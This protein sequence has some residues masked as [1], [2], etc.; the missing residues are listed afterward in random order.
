MRPTCG[1][2][3]W[4]CWNA[5][6]DVV[7]RTVCATRS[8]SSADASAKEMLKPTQSSLLH[9]GDKPRT[10][11]RNGCGK[12]IGRVSG[13]S[14]AARYRITFLPRRAFQRHQERGARRRGVGRRKGYEQR[15]SASSCRQKVEHNSTCYERDLTQAVRRRKCT[16]RDGDLAGWRIAST[17]WKRR[18]GGSRQEARSA[19]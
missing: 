10:A 7:K 15:T 2:K 9:A 11:G 5:M 17:A 6:K 13:T 3:M 19:E 1:G 16:S 4:I 14:V 12:R 18:R 8:A